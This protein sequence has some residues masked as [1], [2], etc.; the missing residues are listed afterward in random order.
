MSQLTPGQLELFDLS[1]Q[2]APL[3]RR[4]GVGR[5]SFAVRHDQMIL[6][7]IG[8]LIGL[9]VVFAFG[10]ERGK[11]IA[12]HEQS[13]SV[14]PPLLA[15]ANPVIAAPEPA[16]AAPVAVVKVA[17]AAVAAEQPDEPVKKFAVQ[18][19]TYSQPQLARR[20]L[21]RLQDTGEKAFLVTRKGRTILYAGPFGSKNHASEKLLSLKVRYQD[22][23]VKTL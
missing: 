7:A 17:E 16:K 4:E 13:L 9:T 22:G 19:V 18:L 14:E 1:R 5:F 8:S 10:V 20:E 23:F 3:L 15:V 11:Q 2:Q 21:Q 12:R 6:A